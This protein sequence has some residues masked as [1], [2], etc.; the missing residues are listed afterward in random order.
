M[1]VPVDDVLSVL[2]FEPAGMK[3][4]EVAAKMNLDAEMIGNKL[5]RMAAYGT[6]EQDVSR[7]ECGRRIYRWRHKEAEHA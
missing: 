6:I 3:T 4:V 1:K 5:S 2:R 7:C